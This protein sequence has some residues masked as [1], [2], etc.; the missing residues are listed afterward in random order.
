MLGFG[1][2]PIAPKALQ[3]D[4]LAQALRE[5][6][7]NEN[8]RRNAESVGEKLRHEDSIANAVTFI[9]AQLAMLRG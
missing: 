1:P 6:R 5:L 9:E 4:N 3:V 7:D 2:A 8:F